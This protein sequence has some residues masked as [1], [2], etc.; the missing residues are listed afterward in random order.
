MSGTTSAVVTAALSLVVGYESALANATCDVSPAPVYEQQ[1]AIR[2]LADAIHEVTAQANELERTFMALA[3]KCTIN[4]VQ[5]HV[6][7]EG[8]AKL[9][10]LLTNLRG[11]EVALKNCSVPA[12]LDELHAQLRRSVAKGRSW[13]SVVKSMSDQAYRVPHQI[14]NHADG[15][16]LTA[17]AE[18]ATKRLVVLANA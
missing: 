8:C 12:E 11:I 7:F 17:L 14:D 5:C 10:E 18:N 15:H 9:Q 2:G 13:V 3:K 16:A 1:Q 4:G 6:P